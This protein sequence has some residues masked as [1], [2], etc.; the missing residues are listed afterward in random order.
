MALM[1]NAVTDANLKYIFQHLP[2]SLMLRIVLSAPKA[3]IIQ[4]S[5][6]QCRQN[7]PSIDNQWTN[8]LT[9]IMSFTC[10]ENETVY[11]ASQLKA[12]A[13]I[14]TD[15]LQNMNYF[16]DWPDSNSSVDDAK[17]MIAKMFTRLPFILRNNSFGVYECAFRSADSKVLNTTRQQMV[18]SYFVDRRCCWSVLHSGASKSLM[19]TKCVCC[20]C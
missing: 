11:N 10:H 12:V 1:L 4:I 8:S 6:T 16:T 14:L 17:E 13:K 2:L 7:I 19:Y 9:S 18:N 3:E 20:I 5:N 15:F